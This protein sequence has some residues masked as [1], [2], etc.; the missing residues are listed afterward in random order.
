MMK[1]QRIVKLKNNKY[2]IFIDNECIVTYDNVILDNNLLFKKEIDNKL[3]NKL[4]YDTNYYDIYDRVV[5][6]LFKKRRS[7]KETLLYLN[8]FELNNKDITKIIN[9]LEDLKLINDLD[10]CKAYINDKVYLSKMGTNKIKNELL[11]QNIPIEIIERELKLI[12]KNIINERLEKI[13]IKKINSNKKYSNMLL[14]QKIINDMINLGYDKKDI[15]VI[16]DKNIKE[17][18]E[19]IKKEFDKLYGKLKS[20]YNYEN[21][22]NIIKSK[23]I[24]RGFK[25][26]QINNLIQEKTEE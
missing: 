16:I 2:K 7:K 22:Y 20:K 23:L 14:K 10:Y 15:E 17:D 21:I 6:Y 26:N 25:I 3:Y 12:D 13:I 1:I 5:K 9:K 11:K 8:K 24:A 4:I 19:I 18:N